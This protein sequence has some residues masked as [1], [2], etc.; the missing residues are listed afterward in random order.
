MID[1]CDLTAMDF[2]YRL[3]T[4]IW[5]AVELSNANAIIWTSCSRLIVIAG[6]VKP[7]C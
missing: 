4:S 7:M 5:M 2:Q 3:T 6:F 1:V